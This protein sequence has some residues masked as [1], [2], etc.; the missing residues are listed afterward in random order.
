MYQSI[1]MQMSQSFKYIEHYID[2]LLLIKK[3][4]LYQHAFQVSLC[5]LHYNVMIVW[6]VEYFLNFY[7]I[8]MFGKIFAELDFILKLKR[9]LWCGVFQD[10][11]DFYGD[12]YLC[13]SIKAVVYLWVLAFCNNITEKEFVILY[14]FFH[15]LV[16]VHHGKGKLVLLLI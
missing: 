1:C 4:L 8:L 13:V 5:S 2:Y 12:R 10:G 14:H 15:V 16:I 11:D 3:F 7:D 9:L 6:C